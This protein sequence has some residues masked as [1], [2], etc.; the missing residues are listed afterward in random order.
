MEEYLEIERRFFVDAGLGQPWRE[1]LRKSEISQFYLDAELFTNI[2][3][4][5]RYDEVSVGVVM[6]EVERLLFES[7]RSW[8]TRIRIADG[9]AILT[10]KGERTH[11][12]ATEL[13]WSIPQD[14][15][16]RILDLKKYP[17]IVKTRFYWEGTD[18]MVWEIDEFDGHHSGLVL[19]EVELPNVHHKTALPE[20]LGEEI[21]G[22]HEW[23]NST[24]SRQGFE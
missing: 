3:A 5:L 16:D 10:L 9:N 14:V 22:K 24:L 23:S 7:T 1:C 2:E 12:S 15:A 17:S 13:E 11:A 6:N 19:A 20:W 18:G 21:T 8:T 4:D